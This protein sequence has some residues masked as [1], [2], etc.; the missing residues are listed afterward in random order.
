MDSV[1]ADQTIPT[2]VRVIGEVDPHPIAD[3]GD[4][5]KPPIGD[6]HRGTEPVHCRPPQHTVQ[7]AA[8]EGQLRYRVIGPQ[9]ALFGTT[10][11]DPGMSGSAARGC[12]SPP[13]PV[14]A[15]DRAWPA[16][17][18]RW[19]QVN[20]HTQLTHLRRGLEHR[21]VDTAFVQRQRQGQT[22]DSAASDQYPHA[23][24]PFCRG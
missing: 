12:G 19:Q 5:D 13:R 6:H 20:A 2:G 23:F 11:A 9:S 18:R 7:P 21:A 17:R 1:R 14:R 10:P 8:M 16:P 15:A 3:I 22:P 4:F 24:T